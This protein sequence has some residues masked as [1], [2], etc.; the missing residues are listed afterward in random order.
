MDLPLALKYRPSSFDEVIGQEHVTGSLMAALSSKQ[1]HNAYLFS[2]PRGCGKTSSARILARSL[3]CEEGPTANPCG[4]CQS[5]RDLIANGPGS[6]DVIEMDAATHGLVDDAREL[7]DKALFAPVRSRY[8]VYILDEAHQ[9]GPA[10]ANALLKIVEEPPPYVIFIFAT[11]EPERVIPTIRSRTHHY[12]FRLVSPDSLRKHLL[13]V[14]EKE[15]V[16]LEDGALA[17][18]VRA[19]AGSVRDSLS[20][21]GQLLNGAVDRN[22]SYE[23]ALQLLGQTGNALLSGVTKGLQS[24]NT[25]SL[26]EIIY[27]LSQSG[28]DLRRFSLDLLDHF[29][30][31]VVLNASSGGHT[32]LIRSYTDEER[33]ALARFAHE[34]PITTL[35]TFTEI[36]ADHLVR[37]R[38][39]TS[40]E[41]IV[42]MMMIRLWHALVKVKGS[43]KVRSGDS[44]DPETATGDDTDQQVVKPGRVVEVESARQPVSTSKVSIK[45]LKTIESHWP[46]VL[47]EVKSIRRL[48]WT[49]LSPHS[50][51][52]LF[53]G[54]VVKIALPSA[55]AVDSFDRSNSKDVLLAAMRRVFEGDFTIE[56]VT[57]AVKQTMS[58]I[59]H[60]EDTVG[61]TDA[62]SGEEL[63]MKTLGAKVISKEDL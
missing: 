52:V 54:K 56:V 24:E 33:V 42:E 19:G 47:E 31:L 16:T 59:T 39:T 25:S 32:R 17:L 46:R 55:G 35:I 12:Q 21:L 4:V 2:G 51:P 58:Q 20:A 44:P 34:V 14:S 18:A 13:E 8:K 57:Q 45:D 5:C 28:N 3:N 36:V 11:T 37:F 53:E 30:D 38:T 10:A 41:V 48:T 1:I 63:L 9:L 7:R 61:S 6:L 27:E 29:R 15:G 60:D 50:F 43:S 26:L 22:V 23:S 40:P 49:L 62:A